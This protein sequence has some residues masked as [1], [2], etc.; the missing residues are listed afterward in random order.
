MAEQL[1]IT[2]CRGNIGRSP[3]AEAVIRQEL[4]RRNLSGEIDVISRGVQG[5][6]ADE[7]PVKY[8]N[9][10]YY[11]KLYADAKPVLDAF[12]VDL[13]QHV[14]RPV[15]Q[16]D[17]QRA[18]LVLAADERT[19]AGLSILFPDHVGIIHL[20][21]ELVGERRG[22]VDPDGVSGREQQEKIYTDIHQIVR[23]GFPRLL[24]L[25]GR[26]ESA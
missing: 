24:Q 4:A 9:I 13:S 12:G 11:T 10:T 22:I 25:L 2:V 21:S 6:A 3:F 20:L 19:R 26:E 15:R 7:E 1:V 14:S 18:D 17:I 16:E 23:N 5:T 8:P